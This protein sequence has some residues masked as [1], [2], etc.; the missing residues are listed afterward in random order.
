MS[1]PAE[2]NLA[3]LLDIPAPNGESPTDFSIYVGTGDV[4]GTD[5]AEEIRAAYVQ[6]PED[7]EALSKREIEQFRR[8]MRTRIPPPDS[9]RIVNTFMFEVTFDSHFQYYCVHHRNAFLRV[10]NT[11]PLKSL[12]E[13]PGFFTQLMEH[14][15]DLCRREGKTANFHRQ[16][17]I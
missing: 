15:Y 1:K 14:E 7:I 12:L 16:P 13:T 4:N 11:K 2:I 9:W 17:D 10:G 5:L 8:L 3:E 6:E